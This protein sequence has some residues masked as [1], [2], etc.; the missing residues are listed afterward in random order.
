M[1]VNWV[2]KKIIS[3]TTKVWV[4]LCDDHFIMWYVSILWIF[5]FV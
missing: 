5:K 4:Q 1:N 2:G 3:Y